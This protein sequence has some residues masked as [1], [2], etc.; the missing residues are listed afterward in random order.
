[1]ALRFRFA[2]M[3]RS[4]DCEADRMSNY[5]MAEADGGRQKRAKSVIGGI[6]LVTISTVSGVRITDECRAPRTRSNKQ[7]ATASARRVRSFAIISARTIKTTFS[8]TS[9]LSRAGVFHAVRRSRGSSMSYQWPHHHRSRLLS[10]Q[11][12]FAPQRRTKSRGKAIA[13]M[14]SWIPDARSVHVPRIIQYLYVLGK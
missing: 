1:M 9:S 12:T 10:L 7:V 6:C 2:D 8:A 4:A 5:R 3:I 13:R 11:P 14:H